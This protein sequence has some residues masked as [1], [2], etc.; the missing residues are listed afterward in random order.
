[1]AKIQF[2]A[3]ATDARGKIAGI[4]YSKNR[5][6]GFVRQKVSPTQTE[7]QRRGLVRQIFAANAQ[8][9]SLGLTAAQVAAWNAFAS[10]HLVTDVFGASHALSGIQVFQKLNSIIQIA[11]GAAIT[12][13]PTSL[14]IVSLLTA[15]V[16]MTAGAPDVMSVAYTPTPTEAN[17][18]LQVFATRPLP[19]GRTFT[20]ADKRW[21]GVS[22]A[23]AASP[24]NAAAAY[25][26]KFGAMTAGRVAGVWVN[27]VNK[28]TGAQTVPMYSLVTIG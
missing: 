21:L 14:A 22:T 3:V 13:P 1:M 23:A 16:T 20:K 8:T 27:K 11:G 18:V 6:G 17:V 12:S 26:A 10:S 9:W 4:V 15:V 28:V 7:T 25:L 19:V 5:A 24:Y 2:G